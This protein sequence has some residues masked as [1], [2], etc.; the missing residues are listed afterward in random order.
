MYA[1]VLRDRFF[2]AA[3]RVSGALSFY[4]INDPDFLAI[5]NASH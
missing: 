5:E 4:S 3:V 2:I 1:H